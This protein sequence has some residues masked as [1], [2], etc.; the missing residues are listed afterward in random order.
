MGNGSTT[1]AVISDIHGNYKA[2][3]AFLSCLERHPA[4]GILCLGDYVTDSPYPQKTMKLI[5]A[6]RQKYPCYMIRGNREN[7]LLE[8]ARES[9]GWKPSSAS[10]A[11]YYTAMRMT[12]RDIQFFAGLSEEREVKLDG[13]PPVYLCHGTPGKVRGN[14]NVEQGLRE[15]ALENISQK[16]LFGGHSHHQEIF[17]AQG[18]MYLNPGSLGLAIDG[19]GRRAQFATVR[20]ERRDFAETAEWKAELHSIP[21]DVESFLQDFAESGLDECGMVLNRAVKKTLVTGINYFFEGILLAQEL[22]GLPV[23]EVP[24]SVW[25]KAA[26]RLEL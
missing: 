5:Y 2:L 7:Y 23:S 18:K 16:Y 15:Q 14:V 3:E 22:S 21:Y 19:V 20:C 13:C 25:Q 8:N 24:E 10:G 4:D 17:Y 1:L 9:Q 11:L 26:E 12:E 6:M